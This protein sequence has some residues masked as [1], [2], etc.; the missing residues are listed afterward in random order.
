[1]HP[2]FCDQPRRFIPAS[3]GNTFSAAFIWRS[4]SVHPRERGEHR[5]NPL[6]YRSGA[7]S[8]PRARGTLVLR[9]AHLPH[10]RFIPASAGNTRRRALASRWRA[11]H[12]RERGEHF[13]ST[14]TRRQMF[15]S[16]PR[17]RGTR[18]RHHRRLR[19]RRFIPASAGN[20]EQ[21]AKRPGLVPVHP[22]ERGEHGSTA[23]GVEDFSGSSPRARGTRCKPWP[24]VTSP[25]FIPASAG[26]TP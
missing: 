24:C 14:V 23:G 17:A 12:P 18:R 15:G 5:L 16:S 6:R 19:Q 26:N 22:R 3:A 10:L 25:R 11:V 20:T 13:R 21:A 4:F 1:M 7:G 2:Q 9:L 8:S